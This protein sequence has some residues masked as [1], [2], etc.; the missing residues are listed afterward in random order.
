MYVTIVIKSLNVPDASANIQNETRRGDKA[1]LGSFFFLSSLVS[2]GLCGQ[3]IIFSRY[4]SRLP[5]IFLLKRG[6][7][8]VSRVPERGERRFAWGPACLL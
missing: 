6:A 8:T 5:S 1:V 4:I 2:C 7:R 3:P